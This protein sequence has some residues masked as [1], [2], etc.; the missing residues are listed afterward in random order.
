MVVNML[1]RSVLSIGRSFRLSAMSDLV[2]P[3]SALSG[4]DSME[5]LY[6]AAALTVAIGVM[7]PT[8]EA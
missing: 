5:V 1:M 3:L 6:T 7:T 2:K 8:T 4:Q